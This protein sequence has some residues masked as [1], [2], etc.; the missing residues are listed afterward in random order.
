M[1]SHGR[2]IETDWK[3][4]SAR[5]IYDTNPFDVDCKITRARHPTSSNYILFYAIQDGCFILQTIAA[6]LYLRVKILRIC[7]FDFGIFWDYIYSIP[8]A[9]PT[10]FRIPYTQRRLA[11]TIG[12][13]TRFQIRFD[14]RTL[15][16]ELSKF[17]SPNGS[18]KTIEQIHI[19]FALKS[20]GRLSPVREPLC[21]LRMIFSYH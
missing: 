19:K 9:Y 4:I 10:A 8:S 13:P 1:I 5:A 18:I 17:K 6:V 3:H 14:N 12:F 20:R 7:E 2:L 11:S 15:F 21:I 16:A